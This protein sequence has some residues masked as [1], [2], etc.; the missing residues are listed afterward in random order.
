[1]VM[2]QVQSDKVE[3]VVTTSKP[4]SLLCSDFFLLANSEIYHVENFFS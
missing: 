3:I 2:S 1:M 4:R